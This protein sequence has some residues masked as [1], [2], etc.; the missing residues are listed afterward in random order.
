MHHLRVLLDQPLDLL[1]VATLDRIR[2]GAMMMVDDEGRGGGGSSCRR[3]Q[4][5]LVFLPA[6]RVRGGRVCDDHRRAS[7]RRVCMVMIDL[8]THRLCHDMIGLWLEGGVISSQ[9]P[10]GVGSMINRI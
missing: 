5:W 1:Q 4:R 2:I 10:L 6:D 3:L 8:V 9:R 7:G